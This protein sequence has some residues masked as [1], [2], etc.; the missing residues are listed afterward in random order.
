MSVENM[1]YC[2]YFDIDENYFPCIDES[3]VNSGAPW[4]NT[5]PHET[6]LSLLNSAEKML[7][8]RT[9]KSLWIHGA[10][11][12]GKS[13]C[14]HTLRKI[15][16]APEEEVK[17]YWNK[18]EPLKQKPLLLQKFL[19]HKEQGVVTAYLYATGE[20]HSP[21][22]LF[23]AV[24]ESVKKSLE[25]NNVPYKG[26]NSLKESV[27]AWLEDPAHN[28]F[29][30]NLLQKQEWVSKFSV[31]TADEIK[32]T[33][34]NSA[35]VSD[36]MNNLFELS[37]KEGITVFDLTADTLRNWL[38]DIIDKNQIKIVLIWD[39]FSD[40]FRDN[41]NSLSEFQKIVT[42]CQLK[43]FYFVIVTHPITSLVKG[44]DSR[45]KSN[46]LSVVQD[47]FE[48]VEITLPDNI[49]FNLIGAAFSIK[50]AAKSNWEQMTADL[51]SRVNSAIK[52]IAKIA[53]IE[54]TA[55]MKMIPVQ[56]MAAL[57]LKNIASAFQSNQRSIFN[58]IKTKN[59][60]DMDVKAFQWFIKNTG[61]LS[62]RPLLTVDMLW[63]FFYEKGKDELSFDI[64]RILDTFGQYCQML[65]EKEKAVLKTVL[66]M[67]AINER[68]AGGL[69]IINPT[70]QNLKY[71]FEGDSQ[72]LE[73]SCLSIANALVSKGILIKRPVGNVEEAYAA[74]VLA[75]DGAKIDGYKEEIRKNCAATSKLL[76]E[77]SD[78][79]TALSLSPALKLRYCPDPQNGKLL[80]VCASSFKRVMDTLKSKDSD[81]HFRAVLALEKNE[82]E[83]QSFRAD[84]K[85]IISDPAY[86][87]IVVIDALSTPLGVENFDQYVEY[88]AMSMYYNGNDKRQSQENAKKAKDILNR[89]WKNRI[90]DG[91]FYVYTHDNQNREK[92]TGANEVQI[93]MQ[94]IV[95][96]RFKYIPD[97]AKGI[98]ETQLKLTQVKQVAK[99]GITGEVKGLIAGCEKTV[100]GKVWSRENYWEAKELSN[101][102]IVIIKKS[103]DKLI[104]EA[105][106]NCG[107]ISIDEI[108][109]FLETNF[110]FSVCNLSAFITGFL[111]REY[112]SEPYRYM[113]SEGRRDSMTP[114]KLA[115]MIG[116]YIGK[117]NP[118]TTYIVSLTEE[119]KAFYELTESA[120]GIT[121]N[122]CTAPNQ[123]GS[124]VASKMRNL[125][126]PVWCLE[127][128][129]SKGAI[130]LVKLYIK[131]VQSNGDEAHNVANEIGKTAISQP[132]SDELLKSLLTKDNCMKGMR[133]FLEKFEGGKLLSL[134]KEI[135]ATDSVLTDIKELFSVQYFALWSDTTG[136]DEIRKLITEYEVISLTNDLLNVRAHNKE[137]A[138]KSWRETLKFVGFSCELIKA[139]HPELGKFF[140]R[141]LQITNNED[142]LPDAMKSFYDEMTRYN[143]DIRGLFSNTLAVFIEL[144]KP[145][146]EGLSDTDCESI[147]KSI[148][149][150]MFVVSSTKSNEIVKKAVENHRK[151]QVKFQLLKL[152]K[153]KTDGTKSP[154]DWSE[155]Y[156]TPILC[157]IEP[158]RYS[159]AKR[160]FST[161][162]SSMQS[163]AEINAALSFL[164]NTDI[165]TDISNKECRD[166]YFKKYVLGENAVLLTDLEE[167]RTNLEKTGISAY[168]WND[169]PIIK[170]KVNSMALNE[171]NA[172][173]S[174]KAIDIIEQM[175][176]AERRQ[177]LIDTV[178]K[179]KALGMKII[180]NKE[181]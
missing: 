59:D 31:S 143:A 105:F 25:L 153:D 116:N 40:F 71:A 20:I 38:V 102:Y 9:N 123:A 147:K 141:L 3:A 142:I 58:F 52:A 122:T 110:G 171:Y 6:F 97:F 69:R 11:G 89:D 177:W 128:V 108:C 21:R 42:I 158:S 66:I 46:P 81:W 106:K 16:D 107:K 5:Y 15:L 159:E 1:R 113:D 57:F 176:D 34:K 32:N 150:N 103:I 115:E 130:E 2:E 94:T 8:G 35:E 112:C 29:M 43:P 23:F 144:Y 118:K 90:H 82:E 170:D 12:T 155:R 48:K 41:S 151:K 80:V 24:Q 54:E 160:A 27:I 120:W 17:A 140:D 175:T 162:N 138:F 124:L 178:H 37:E 76:E 129:D 173:G 156:R 19:G 64:K 87:N 117:A 109:D 181:N 53:N 62:D 98:T 75:G 111:L 114:D 100:L 101:E 22:K 126:Y 164:E 13:Q 148:T 137:E 79:A 139:K 179:D 167:V 104:V 99:Y 134:A 63:D 70:D 174:D 73:N 51:S 26:E 163:E 149:A 119:E 168:D 33:L 145:Y 135:G 28:S 157:C 169:N 56:P 92:V 83:A 7:S 132:C 47:R 55:I 131:L 67:Q 125:S 60:D 72:E 44:Y 36:L 74:A 30:N 78:I 161:L 61:P 154:R 95:L 10:Y 172:G 49:A 152:W 85:K 14:V 65:N 121:P 133:R 39:E 50:P 84:I 127:E 146:L 45:D 4:D 165:F 68:L 91:I 166:Y 18:Y 77:G 93:I 86:K 88:S 136:E 180:T 96:N